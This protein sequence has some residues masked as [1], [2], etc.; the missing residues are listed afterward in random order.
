MGLL[1]T[2]QPALAGTPVNLRVSQTLVD[3]PQITAY[4]DI[5]DENG[6]PVTDLKATDVGANVG[7]A[8]V[9]VTDIKLFDQS[10][11][12]IA[13]VLLVDISKSL[14][15][16]QFEQIQGALTAWV[17]AMG[18]NDRAAIIT[19]ANAVKITQHFIA[20]KKGL[21]QKITALAMTDEQ[22]QLHRGL[23]QAIETARQINPELPN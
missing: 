1:A 2:V 3:L 12:G 13:Y 15:Q 23:A 10:D 16:S 6:A 9:P 22:T 7:A 11:E 14:Q 5:T 4:F 20:D 18:S 17:E 8:G 19:L 21:N